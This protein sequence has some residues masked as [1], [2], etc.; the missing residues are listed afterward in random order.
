MIW[1]VVGDAATQQGRLHRW[2]RDARHRQPR[3]PSQHVGEEVNAPP[4]TLA[5]TPITTS[6]IRS[7][8]NGSFTTTFTPAMTP[9]TA[10]W[11]CSTKSCTDIACSLERAG[12]RR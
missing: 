10:F 8:L 12:R 6:L 1:L 9:V 5:V 11:T 7:Y 3:G 2:A 4:D